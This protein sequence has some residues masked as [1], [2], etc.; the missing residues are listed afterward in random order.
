M[1]DSA[2]HWDAVY[3]ARPDDRTS[4]HRA[5]LDASLRLLDAIG[6]D[7]DAPIVDIGGGRSSFVDDLL[8]RGHRD[9]SVLDVS[10]EALAQV[11]ERLGAAGGNV[12]WIG[13]DVTSVELPPARYA[14][15]HDRA[16]FHF[17]VDAHARSRYAAMLARSVRAGGHAIV[18]TFAP[19][20]PERCS[21]LPAN[22]Y[23]A[24]SLAVQF[25]PAFAL[26]ESERDLHRTPTGA[27]Q[28]FTYALL[29]RG[30]AE[31]REIRC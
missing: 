9:V 24:A 25:A 20:G 18:A 10:L 6:L 17:L 28:A 2:H 8:A 7:P 31:D 27:V 5:R 21:G 30:G 1:S 13:A 19:D 29:R 23:D 3:R 22:R 16:V 14:L 26:I 4:W 12:H 15:W 11:R